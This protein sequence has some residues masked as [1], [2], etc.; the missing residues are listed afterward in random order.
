MI[1]ELLEQTM[2]ETDN[3]EKKFKQTFSDF[4]KEPPGD[5]WEKICREIRPENG[6][7]GF[8]DR[9]AM[10]LGVSSRLL[11]ASSWFA[12]AAII[13]FLGIVYL[14]T[15]DHH[16]IRGHAYTGETYLCRGTA[17]LFKVE[18]KVRPFDS[19]KH[20]RS[21]IINE[22]GFFEFP[23]IVPGKYLLRIAPD[24]NSEAEKNFAPS[25]YDE[26]LYPEESHLIIVIADDL[27][28]DVHLIKKKK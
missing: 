14:V 11:R 5:V 22:N 27:Y 26:H 16:T 6:S 17:V 28:A 21:A 2:E 12:A 4:S 20:Y 13:L 7:I 25:W 23:R 19:V 8:W 9:N 15:V 18:D 1:W 10:A 24:E 3:L